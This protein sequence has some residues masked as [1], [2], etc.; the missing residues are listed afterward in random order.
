MESKAVSLRK[1]T[2]RGTFD[3]RMIVQSWQMALCNDKSR[4]A[5]HM[6]NR[7]AVSYGH[8]YTVDEAMLVYM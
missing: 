8:A 4:D 5:M 3:F 1:L 7:H 2:A 6:G